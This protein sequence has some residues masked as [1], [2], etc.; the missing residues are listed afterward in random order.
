MLGAPVQGGAEVHGL[1]TRAPRGSSD[2]PGMETPA[3]GTLEVTI[4]VRRAP[5][6]DEREAAGNVGACGEGRPTGGRPFDRP[7]L[8]FD[9]A[10]APFETCFRRTARW[11]NLA[12]TPRRSVLTVP[13]RIAH[14][15]LVA[16]T[17]RSSSTSA[18]EHFC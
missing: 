6:V 3:R 15:V 4:P 17:C 11:T 18:L 16:S 7:V 13:A 10:S 8:T 2:E 12:D 1:A 9:R 5:S 14:H